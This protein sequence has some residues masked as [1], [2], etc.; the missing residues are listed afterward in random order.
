MTK[1]LPSTN[2]F[3]TKPLSPRYTRR[4]RHHDYSRPGKYMITL[5]KA[6]YITSLSQIAGNLSDIDT[7]P[8]RAI[9]TSTGI[10][11]ERALKIWLVK[12]SQLDVPD[13]V[14]MPDHIHFCLVVKSE[15]P[16]GLS[17]AMAVLMGLTSSLYKETC[18]STNHSP[19]FQKGFTD[20]IAYTQNQFEIQKNYV[21]DNP[22]RLL[23]KRLHPDL[24]FKRWIISVNGITL[25]ALGNIFLL[26]NPHICVVRFS[27]KFDETKVQANLRDW[28]RCVEN[29]GA[30]IS[31]FIHPL[32][33]DMRKTA[34]SNG[35]NIIRI[36]DNG[37][38]DRYS[39]NKEEMDALS[40]KKLLLISPVE[41]TSQ[42]VKLKYSFA[43]H[44]NSIAE[45]LASHPAGMT[46]K[47][48]K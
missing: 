40:S 39:P 13:L 10:L 38:S 9:P 18:D 32:E 25:M 45:L 36:L 4:A 33:N 15:L 12:Y 46:L 48:F 31:P 20:S 42:K 41:Y 17:R 43:Q 11:F 30:L 19:F 44:L 8:P 5:K 6:P 7:D 26:K 1:E 34:L 24:F 35:G 21:R 3:Y 28:H 37:F 23:I 14:I 27:R 16:T 2:P 22:R 29:G 47:P